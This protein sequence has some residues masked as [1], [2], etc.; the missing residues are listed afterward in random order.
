VLCQQYHPPED[1]KP[2]II[3]PMLDYKYTTKNELLGQNRVIVPFLACGDL[4]GFDADATYPA[5]EN[6]QY[7][8]P[9]QLPI[10]PP[11]FQALQMKH[12]ASSNLNT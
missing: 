10:D 9:S 11:Y 4:S 8:S 12:A 1:Y 7:H 5:S 3:N 6:Y 2:I